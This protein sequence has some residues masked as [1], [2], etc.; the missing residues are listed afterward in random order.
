MGENRI[1]KIK[2]DFGISAENN[3]SVEKAIQKATREALKKHKLA[4]NSVAVWRD[5]KVVILKPEEIAQT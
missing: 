2:K 5:G 3:L 1:N 4:G